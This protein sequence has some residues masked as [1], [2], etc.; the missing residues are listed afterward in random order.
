MEVVEGSRPMAKKACPSD[1]MVK[2]VRNTIVRGLLMGLWLPLLAA[3]VKPAS[4]AAPPTPEAFFAQIQGLLAKKDIPGYLDLFAPAARDGEKARVT[5]LFDDFKMDSVTLRFA[6]KR[7]AEDGS[8]RLFG[9]AYFQNS[10]MVMIE[11]WQLTAVLSDGRWQVTAKEASGNISTLYKVRIPGGRAERA[12]SVEVEH[13]D[14]RL[15]FTDAAVFYDN[16]PGLETAFLIL[17]KGTVRFTPSDP[18]EKHQ[19]ELLYRKPYLEDDIDFLFVRCSDGF[20]SRNVRISPGAE[21]PAVTPAET[22]RAASLFARVYPRSFTI[23]SSVDK[24]ILSFLPQGDEA[25][26]DFKGKRS[27]DLTYIYYPFSDEQVN[28]YDRGKE[29]I[30]SLY[31]PAEESDQPAKRLYI[32]FAEKFDIDRYELDLSY[33]PSQNYIS[34]KARISVVPRT[35]SLASLKFRFNPD[36]EILK[37]YDQDRRELFYT[38]DNLRKYLY[39]YLIAPSAPAQSFWIEVFYR[40][41][42]TPPV[43][44]SDVVG[45]M[46]SRDQLVFRP[47]YETFFFTQS[48]L[49]YPAPA[50]EDYF[51]ARL[52]L[53]IPPEYRAVSNGELVERGSWDEMGDVVEIEKTGSAIYT[54]Q[55]KVPVKYLSFI[56]G[57]FDRPK[58][59]AEPVPIRAFISTEIPESDPRIVDQARDILEFY[60]KSFGPYPFEKLGIV[61]RLFPTAGGHSPASF[62]VLNEVPWRGNSP[63]PVTADNPVTLSDWDEY[64][65][66]HEIAHQWWGQGVSFDTYKDQWLSEGLSQ[67]AAASYLRSKYGERAYASILRKFAQW[68]EKKSEKGP[69]A[70]GSRLSY[71]DFEAYQAVVYDKAALAMFML[72]DMLGAEV[73][74]AGLRAFF[75]KHKYTAARTEDLVAAMETAS[76]RDLKPFFRGW[77][78]SYE[79][80]VVQTS[81]AEESGPSGPLLKVR[82]T[83][84]KGPFVFPLW[85]EWTSRG[86]THSEMAVIDRASQEVVLSVP[87]PVDKVRINPLRS[88]PGKF[89]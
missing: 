81:W 88:V 87:G 26:F 13:R 41:R 51:R 50:E 2:A 3:A 33:S 14:I 77:F 22:D 36:L 61:K 73:F 45:Q 44:T 52:K 59:A 89:S 20:A 10:T 39:V 25:V 12:R 16:L 79:L 11:S 34:G 63:Y 60:I 6:G 74:R 57:K 80:P 48:G 28:L 35:Q 38:R 42:M 85:I 4:Q 7:P 62:I 46:V 8:T 24:E 1:I 68:T 29:R 30:L 47:R 54:F 67:F 32:S 83:Q 18:I 84:L 82:V 9:Q 86:R 66:A 58:D 64:L 37:I 23:E 56:V 17:G 70:I 5:S 40:G 49:W 19:L 21:G 65:L 53:V 31:S 71:F 43:P 72:Q 55:T 69:I 15:A 27:G 76:G 78:R 75:E